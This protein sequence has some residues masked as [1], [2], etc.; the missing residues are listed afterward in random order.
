[1]RHG[2]ATVGELVSHSRNHLMADVMGLG[3]GSLDLIE[4]ALALQN[5]SLAQDST[6]FRYARPYVR[7]K[8]QHRQNHSTW[9][10]APEEPPSQPEA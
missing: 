1:M 2:I 9:I 7:S 8:T 5:L 10:S 4:E 6:T 3:A